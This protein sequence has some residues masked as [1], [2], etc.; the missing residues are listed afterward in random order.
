MALELIVDTIDTVPEAF[1]SEYTEKDG[2][3]HLAVTGL[4]KTY[5]PRDALTKANNEAAQ[6]RHAL[7]AWETAVAGKSVEDVQTLIADFD[8]GKF[9]KGKTKEEFDAALVQHKTAAEQKAAALV[10]ERDTA[11]T[12]ARKAIVDGELKGALATAKATK[13]GL[14]MLPKILGD[15]IE[16]KFEN[17][18]PVRRIMAADGKSPMIGTGPDGFATLDDLMKDVVKTYPD[19]FEGSG[20][21]GGG[22][23]HK[24]GGGGGGVTMTKAE[25]DALSPK[26]RAAKATQAGFKIV[27]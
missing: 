5:V 18:E 14:A 25:F 10:A 11:Y 24:N 15:R 17:G 1:R 20:A 22:A 8:S 6:R 26:D 4:E 21:G 13:T 3:F 7:T 16:L 12:A 27:G 2:K 19:L 9:N 23:P